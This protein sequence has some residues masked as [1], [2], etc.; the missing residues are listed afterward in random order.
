MNEEWRDIPGFEN[1]YQI[2]THGQV[3]SLSRFDRKGRI[4]IGCI[5]KLTP[6]NNQY[7]YVKLL[8]D[9]NG[10]HQRYE[11][12]FIHR[13]VAICFIP[14]PDR[15]P[16]VNHKDRNRTNN[17]LENLEWCTESENMV[18]WY[19]DERRRRDTGNFTMESDAEV[20]ASIAPEDIPF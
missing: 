11:K 19:E 4:V 9:G 15:K 5:R 8:R 2:S 16:I 7:L 17:V 14:N 13:L 3:K 10:G 6:N 20:L 12:Y 1:R 18:H